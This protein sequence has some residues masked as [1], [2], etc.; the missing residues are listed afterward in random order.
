MAGI[1]KIRKSYCTSLLG[2]CPW[3]AWP[4]LPRRPLPFRPWARVAFGDCPGSAPPALKHAPAEVAKGRGC[5]MSHRPLGYTTRA[6]ALPHQE[7][8]F[9]LSI[10]M[11]DIWPDSQALQIMPLPLEV[12][13]SGPPEAQEGDHMFSINLMPDTV[14]EIV[15]QRV[16]ANMGS[17]LDCPGSNPEPCRLLAVA[18]WPSYLTSLCLRSLICE[19]GIIIIDVLQTYHE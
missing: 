17:G 13:S 6:I 10:Q 9:E 12:P 4:V 3:G 18:P 11:A 19:M 7:P 15:G 1:E 5:G 8:W 2:R 14:L 16:R